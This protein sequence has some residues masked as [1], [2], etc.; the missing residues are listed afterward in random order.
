MRPPRHLRH[1]CYCSSRVAHAASITVA[2]FSALAARALCGHDAAMITVAGLAVQSAR[3]LC[4]NRATLITVVHAASISVAGPMT[5][6]NSH[7]TA[8]FP[9]NHQTNLR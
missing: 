2:D 5:I 1:P 8:E 7:H 9:S 6:A 3:A 4:D